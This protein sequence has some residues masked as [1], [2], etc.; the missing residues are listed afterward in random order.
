MEKKFLN[1]GAWLWRSL[2]LERTN[3]HVILGK[4]HSSHKDASSVCKT[5]SLHH[6]KKC[7]EMKNKI[8]LFSNKGE[9][10]LIVFHRLCRQKVLAFRCWQFWTK[11]LQYKST[12]DV[13]F[14]MI[15]SDALEARTVFE[16]NAQY[17]AFCNWLT[18]IRKSILCPLITHLIPSACP[19]KSGKSPV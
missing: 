5:N 4:E 14:I 13:L 7:N 8:L 10:T 15:S 16:K 11:S 12:L 18:N 1:L 17:H 6:L 3:L 19:Q 9:K 2:T